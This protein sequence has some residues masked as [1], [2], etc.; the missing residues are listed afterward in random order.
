MQSGQLSASERTKLITLLPRLRRFST[1]L[2]GERAGADALL[3]SACRKM[4]RSGS[5]YQQGTAF[6]VWAFGKVHTDWLAELRSHASPLAQ[7]QGA[8]AAFPFEEDS[9]GEADHL[10]ETLEIVAALPAQQRSIALLIYG[11]GFSYE[12][13]AAILDTTPQT[14]VARLSRAL[15]TFIERA[16]WLKSARRQSADIQQLNQMKRQAG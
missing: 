4:L 14:V 6:D 15:S 16:D 3:R 13:A 11:E 12:E 10:A 1:V 9:A 8:T 2:A 5:T 7:A